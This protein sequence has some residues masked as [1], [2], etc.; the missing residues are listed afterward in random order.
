MAA[1]DG[2]FGDVGDPDGYRAEARMARRLG[3]IGKTCIHPSQV[4][5]ANEVFS[6]RDDEVAIS[7]ELLR[8]VVSERRRPPRWPN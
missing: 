7:D 8:T 1:V 6:L 2:A 3:F 4:A 5:L